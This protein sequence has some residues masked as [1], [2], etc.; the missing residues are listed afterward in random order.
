M[1]LDAKIV[2]LY[3]KKSVQMGEMRHVYRNFCLF[4]T[5]ACPGATLGIAVASWCVNFIKIPDHG[6]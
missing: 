1:L 4:G 2:E 5:L 6:S 3:K